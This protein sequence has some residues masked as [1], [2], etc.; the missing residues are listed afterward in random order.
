MPPGKPYLRLNK[1]GLRLTL[2]R[3]GRWGASSQ[4]IAQREGAGVPAPWPNFW[5]D[6]IAHY[7]AIILFCPCRMNY[8]CLR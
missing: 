7:C 2:V 4:L 1:R 3:G 8:L 6:S 5:I